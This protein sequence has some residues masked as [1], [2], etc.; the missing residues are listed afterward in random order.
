[1]LT[2]LLASVVFSDKVVRYVSDWQRS[3]R[4][5]IS[6]QRSNRISKISEDTE[7]FKFNT[8]VAAFGMSLWNGWRSRN[9]ASAVE[10]RLDLVVSICAMSRTS[11]GEK[12]GERGFVEEQSWPSIDS[13][14]LVRDT[15]ELAVQVNGKSA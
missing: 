3:S 4:T 13:V 15:I 2:A 10:T 7:A 14:L 12:I 8:A 1:M 11:V 5:R 6:G 9:D